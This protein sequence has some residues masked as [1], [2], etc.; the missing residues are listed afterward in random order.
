MKNLNLFVPGSSVTPL[1]YK[2]IEQPK[3]IEDINTA[4]EL[5]SLDQ[6]NPETPD[7]NLEDYANQRQESLKN[8]G[9]N[10]NSQ[11]NAGKIE[12]D[13]FAEDSEYKIPPLTPEDEK[14]LDEYFARLEKKSSI[15]GVDNF[16]NPIPQDAVDH[17]ALAQTSTKPEKNNSTEGNTESKEKKNESSE[18]KN[19]PLFTQG[20]GGGEIDFTDPESSD[21]LLGSTNEV[22]TED[23]IEQENLLARV[24][25]ANEDA[26]GFS[27]ENNTSDYT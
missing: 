24:S 3:K 8:S 13:L 18:T 14:A 16:G 26:I 25:D 2:N 17:G 20:T 10:D 15:A 19:K 7:F 4:E 12:E 6:K 22:R 23:V 9:K 5:Q 11:E 21:A 27:E 1:L